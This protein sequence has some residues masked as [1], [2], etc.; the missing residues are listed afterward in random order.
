MWLTY[1]ISWLCKAYYPGY[2]RW[3][4][5]N[6]LKTF[7]EK[8]WHPREENLARKLPLDLNCS[9]S[10]GTQAAGPAGI[11]WTCEASKITRANSLKLIF[12]SLPPHTYVHTHTHIQLFCFS[13]EFWLIH[14]PWLMGCTQYNGYKEA[15]A[16]R[17]YSLHPL[18]VSSA[19]V[20]KPRTHPPMYLPFGS[21][22]FWLQK[23]LQSTSNFVS[24]RLL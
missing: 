17:K 16:V 11:F 9:C 12:H 13:E 22:S 18:H 24:E 1:T 8:D 5:S 15:E 3:A 19:I 14:L 21:I 7:I 20:S 4:S 6:Q 10:L 23:L 2:C